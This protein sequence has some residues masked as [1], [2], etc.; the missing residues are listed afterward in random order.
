M[1]NQI[2][3]SE[4]ALTA[5]LLAAMGMPMMVFYAVGV[6]GPE[7]M[8]TLQLPVAA[9]GWLT[10]ATFGVAATASLV[11]G[12][13][14]SRI[15]VRCSLLALFVLVALSFGLIRMTSGFYGLLMA[16]LVC[17]LAQALAN[18]STNQAIAHWADPERKAFLVGLKQSGVQLSALLA[19]A[20]MPLLAGWFSW[21]DAF[22]FWVPVLIVLVLLGARM[23]PSDQSDR[24][25]RP[26]SVIRPNRALI[27]LALVQLGVGLTLSSFMTYLGVF[28]AEM[29]VSPSSV[30]LMVILFGVTGVL[31]RTLL[32]PLARNWP[33]ESLMLGVLIVGACVALSVM[34]LT[35]Q[36]YHLPLWSAVTGIGATLVATNAIA[37]SML[38]HDPGFGEVPRASGWLSAGFFT[39]FALG[40]PGF[41]ALVATWGFTIALWGLVACLLLALVAVV[42][43]AGHRRRRAELAP[44]SG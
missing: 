30:G 9:L 39:G 33:D 28:A 38:L 40:P 29:G 23:I 6:L 14:V 42:L 34:Q 3:V 13:L 37:M 7:I 19:G 20:L 24:P 25:S 18:P 10:T 21:Q 1:H 15:G 41:G 35:T 8:R 31:A 36:A 44:A 22:L 27:L 43:L 16:L 5:L 26:I 4:P 17:G 11:A 2:R 12:P 32:T